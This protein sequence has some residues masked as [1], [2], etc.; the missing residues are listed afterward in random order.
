[1][2]A[3]PGNKKKMRLRYALNLK[4]GV[5]PNCGRDRGPDNWITCDVCREAKRKCRPDSQKQ[6]EYVKKQRAKY[7]A[8]GRCACGRYLT[9]G[10]KHC[11]VCL[12]RV[13][14]YYYNVVKLKPTG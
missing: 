10:K 2:K 8:Q 14:A 11:E 6:N 5:C 3:T 4:A 12:E 9:N 7:R 13:R 1:M